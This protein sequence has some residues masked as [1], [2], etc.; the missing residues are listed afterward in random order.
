LQVQPAEPVR[1]RQVQLACGR[2]ILSHAHNWYVPARLTPA[3]NQ[4]LDATATPFGTVIAPLGF[5]RQR[6]AALRGPAEGCP[7]DTILSHRAVL[8]LPGGQPVST[9]IECYTPAN[10]R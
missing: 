6:L 3:M 9:V 5:T 10:L 1:Y 7:A 8:T 2:Q 4:A